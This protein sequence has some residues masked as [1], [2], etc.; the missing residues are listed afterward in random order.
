MATESAPVEANKVLTNV[1]LQPPGKF[2][3]ANPDGWLKWKRRFQQ[4]MS[5]SSLDKHE[6]DL[7]YCLGDDADEVLTSTSITAEERKLYK[8]VLAKLD[9]FFKVRRNVIYERARFN[10]RD[11][12]QGESSE[13]YIT[14]LY[15]LVELCEYGDM[16]EQLLHDRL[17]VGITD[18]KLSEQLQMDAGL[19]LEKAK[20]T[21]RQKEA[22]REQSR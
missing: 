6:D 9:E 5:A 16:K 15:K 12:K 11:Q 3:F 7:L 17:V 4:F 19:M 8:G 10:K 1:A 22:D 14:E 13:A 2:N 18:K 20:K 21:I